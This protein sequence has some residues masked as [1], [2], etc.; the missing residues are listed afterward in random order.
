ML[1]YMC[2]I[3]FLNIKIS[4]NLGRMSKRVTCYLWFGRSRSWWA[5]SGGFRSSCLHYMHV[6]QW[7]I[8][9]IG[10]IN[11]IKF[12]T[13]NLYKCACA[14]IYAAYYTLCRVKV[15]AQK[16]VDTPSTQQIGRIC[17]G[18]ARRSAWLQRRVNRS[19]EFLP[20]RASQF[21]LQLTRRESLS[22][23]Y[24]G[25]CQSCPG[26]S[27]CAASGAARQEKSTKRPIREEI[28]CYGL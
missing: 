9:L 19:C 26:S 17:L 18:W 3:V 20:R 2:C 10:E 21:D 1:K 16:R 23:I 6:D 4:Y 11:T 12:K 8:I 25:T 14:S 15:S 13:L 24:D 27:K 7:I 28:G 22:V 5:C